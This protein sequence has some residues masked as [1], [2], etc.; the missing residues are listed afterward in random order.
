MS[1][2][3][4]NWAEKSEINAIIFVGVKI[5]PMRYR[6]ASVLFVLFL[7]SSYVQAQNAFIQMYHPQYQEFTLLLTDSLYI[8]TESTDGAETTRAVGYRHV[9]NKPVGWREV[10]G[11][12]TPI[13]LDIF[14]KRREKP[15][16]RVFSRHDNQCFPRTY[17][18][19][20]I[21]TI[22]TA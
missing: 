12:N 21:C 5:H 10:R 7:L 13:L 14:E 3:G 17:A 4:L 20:V 11:M 8:H 18:N 2:N 1:R 16:F 6:L 19:L 22:P 9:E 15:D